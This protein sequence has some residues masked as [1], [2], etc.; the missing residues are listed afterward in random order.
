MRTILDGAGDPCERV[1][2]VLLPPAYGTA[3]DFV[4]HGFIAAI[5]ARDLPV[6]VIAA[7]AGADYYLGYTIVERL[8]ADVIAPALARGYRRL[9][10]GGISLG[11]FGGLLYR[12][13]H[14]AEVEGLLLIAPY[15][16]ARPEVNEVLLAG[17]LA[18]WRPAAIA[19]DDRER[20]LLAWL[21]E[22]IADPIRARTLHA[23]FGTEDRFARSIELLAGALPP[24]R[25][26]RVAGGHDWDTWAALWGPM[27]DREPF[28]Q[29][30]GAGADRIR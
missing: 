7:D 19:P 18:R 4:D 24:E 29:R 9:W 17:G 12:E 26:L 27:L 6:D 3:Q 13:A 8:H 2:L 28:G 1:L 10:L 15:L 25:V 21:K 30:G 16:G 14:A 5:R 20:R 11:G 22:F 23:A